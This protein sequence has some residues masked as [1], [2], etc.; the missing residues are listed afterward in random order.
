M[1]ESSWKRH[2]RQAC[3]PACFYCQQERI[4]ARTNEVIVTQPISSDL[5]RIEVFKDA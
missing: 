3:D 5:D 1:K 2:T 4:M